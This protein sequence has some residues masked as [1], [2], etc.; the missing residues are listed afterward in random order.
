MGFNSIA[1]RYINL[2]T[3]DLMFNYLHWYDLD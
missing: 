1:W 2:C 3:L